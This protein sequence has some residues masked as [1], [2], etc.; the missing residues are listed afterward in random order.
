MPARLTMMSVATEQTVVF[1]LRHFPMKTSG[2]SQSSSWMSAPTPYVAMRFGTSRSRW[3][4]TTGDG[5]DSSKRADKV[6]LPT[7]DGPPMM[8]SPVATDADGDS[9]D[10][11]CD[12]D[13]HIV[14]EETGNAMVFLREDVPADLRAEITE[15]VFIDRDALVELRQ[16]L[17]DDDG[18]SV[19]WEGDSEGIR[20]LAQDV[21]FDGI[22][23]ATAFMFGGT[24]DPRGRWTLLKERRGL[25]TDD[26]LG[27][28]REAFGW[29][30][31]QGVADDGIAQASRSSC[32]M[33]TGVL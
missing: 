12:Y 25:V 26:L 4:V 15:S 11:I 20:R 17:L 6:V 18:F 3:T 28:D 32:V 21:L 30:W 2:V 9:I 24:G 33:G 31:G 29:D 10:T 22:C 27:T 7:R 8:T 14:F 16:D 13:K 5:R 19:P 1:L 23:A